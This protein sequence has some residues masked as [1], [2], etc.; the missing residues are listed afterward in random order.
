M[1]RIALACFDFVLPALQGDETL[2][3]A[4]I[5]QARSEGRLDASLTAGY[6]RMNSS[7]PVFGVNDRGPAQFALRGVAPNPAQH[8]L[9]V[10]F[11]LK[12]SK[13]ATL[14]LFDVS[15]RQL[16]ARRVDGMGPGWHTMTLGGGSDLPAGLYVIR[17]TQDGRSLATRAAVIR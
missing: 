9:Q 2:A 16:A 10:S 11:S 4:R 14:T 8:E 15:G 13:V 5:E 12:D 3:E 7:F 17:L 6:E 1:G